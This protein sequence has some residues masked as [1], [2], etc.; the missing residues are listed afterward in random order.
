MAEKKTTTTITAAEKAMIK[1]YEDYMDWASQWAANNPAA[2]VPIAQLLAGGLQDV[3]TNPNAVK[4]GQGLASSQVDPYT[5]KPIVGSSATSPT[6]VA[7]QSEVD[8]LQAAYKA[9]TPGSAAQFRAA[10]A[11]NTA[12]Y[13]LS[14]AN[15]VASTTSAAGTGIGTGTGATSVTSGTIGA[16]VT[17]AAKTAEQR[18]AFADFKAALDSWG[19]GDLASWATAL[20]QSENAPVN[21]NEFYM[22]MKQQP[23]YVER[24]GKTNEA[25]QKAGLPDLTEAQIMSLEGEYK[26]TMKAYNMPAGFYDQPSDFRTFIA[27]DLSASEVADRVQAANAFV[28]MQ[29]PQIRSEL[30]GYYG[31][32]DAALTAAALDP[33]K[34]QSILESIASRSTL[35]IAAGTAGLGTQYAEQAAGVGGGELGFEKQ[36][37]AFAQAASAG[38]RGETLSQIYGDQGAQAYGMQ[39]AVTEAFGGPTAVQESQKRRK[40]ASMEENVFGGASG[41]GQ[42]SLGTTPTAGML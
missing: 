14:Q 12:Q 16:T 40:L 30:S 33:D 36:S 10:E 28:K 29:S 15:T 3:S 5:G 9:A 1:E 20:Y 2:N 11:L 38:A 42:T 4:T 26:K 19:L 35:A 24:F 21:Y 23:V 22:Q 32:S 37:A 25:R 6:V 31:I 34:G 7:A 27:N 17:D 8:R 39:Q 18:S 41:M 13:N